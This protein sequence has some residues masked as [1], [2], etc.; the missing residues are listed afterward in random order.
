[1]STITCKVCAPGDYAKASQRIASQAEPP[2]QQLRNNGLFSADVTFHALKPD[3]TRFMLKDR[4]AKLASVG[5]G[6]KNPVVFALNN[7]VMVYGLHIRYMYEL[8]ESL[9]AVNA[10]YFIYMNL[11]LCSSHCR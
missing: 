2:V 1:M 4:A 5:K 10:I 6:K 8:L 9:F 11:Y 3:V 7:T